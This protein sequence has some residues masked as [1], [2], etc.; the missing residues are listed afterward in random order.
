MSL[1]VLLKDS[2]YCYP[3][4]VIGFYFSNFFLPPG[5]ILSD[6]TY[7]RQMLDAC[8]F[9]VRARSDFHVRLIY[10]RLMSDFCQFRVG[11]SSCLK[12]AGS[13][14]QNH[15]LEGGDISKL[16]SR[17]LNRFLEGRDS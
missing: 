1:E 6:L 17:I 8:Q 9:R 10:V 14:M 2:L 7:V 12:L 3:V 15:F 5:A 11:P 13:K 16:E 4:G